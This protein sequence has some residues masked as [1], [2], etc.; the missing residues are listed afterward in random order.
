MNR[1]S[2]LQFVSVLLLAALGSGQREGLAQDATAPRK[3]ADVNFRT[4]PRDFESVTVKGRVFRVEKQLLG[5]SPAIADRVLRRLKQNIDLALRILPPHSHEQVSKQRFYLLYGP[6]ARGGG[7]DRGLAY[8]RPGS[9]KFDE[10]RH[11]DWNSVIVV[12]HAENYMK[13]SDFWALK[14]VVHEMA[15]AYHLEQWPE[16]Q[17]EILKA[18]EDAM[19]AELYRNIRDDKG[20]ILKAAYATRN[21]LEYFAELSCMFFSRCNYPPFDWTEL[22]AYDPAGYDMIRRQWKIGDEYG[23][24]EPRVWTIG[25]KRRPLTATLSAVA[26]NRVTLTDEKGR[27]R[28][29]TLKALSP[30]DQ[31]HIRLWFG[32]PG[33]GASKKP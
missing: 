30:V 19:Q 23:T 4:P 6:K 31:D 29:M 14:A 32:S 20:K 25:S 7:W 27:K 17:P 10:R 16:K 11:K 13:L 12:F 1:R 26:G 15:H 24:R 9:P 22:Q 33:D 28:T 3:K 21:Q 5:E 2:F 8:Y 18:W